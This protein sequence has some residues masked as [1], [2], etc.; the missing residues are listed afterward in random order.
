M[1]RASLQRRLLLGAIA[2]ILIALV[3]TAVVL[4][5]LF[6]G[7][8]E[9]ELARRLDADFLQLVSQLDTGT[10]GEFALVTMCCGGGL[11]TGTLLQRI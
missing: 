9:D 3:A 6:R 7:H 5:L 8:L 10:D 11:G 1:P 4:S 2:W